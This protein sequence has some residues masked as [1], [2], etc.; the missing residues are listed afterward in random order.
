MIGRENDYSQQTKQGCFQLGGTSAGANHFRGSLPLF[1]Q[2]QNGPKM[3][4]KL[5]LPAGPRGSQSAPAFRHETIT[6]F[7]FKL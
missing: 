7:L 4:K 5:H 2:I 1:K 6:P 3:P